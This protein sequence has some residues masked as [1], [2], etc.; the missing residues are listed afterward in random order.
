[1]SGEELDVAAAEHLVWRLRSAIIRFIHHSSER[2]LCCC[3]STLTV[4]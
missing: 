4:S 1:L 2:G 3:A